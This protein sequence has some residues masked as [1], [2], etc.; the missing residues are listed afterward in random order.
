MAKAP[1]GRAIFRKTMFSLKRVEATLNLTRRNGAVS[2]IHYLRPHYNAECE[3]FLKERLRSSDIEHTRNHIK[4]ILDLANDNIFMSGKRNPK[5][6]LSLN[7]KD[8]RTIMFHWKSLTRQQNKDDARNEGVSTMLH[9]LRTKKEQV[10]V[11]VLSEEEIA[12]GCVTMVD[13]S[14]IV[15]LCMEWYLSKGFPLHRTNK[16]FP[17]KYSLYNE[18]D[19]FKT[20]QEAAEMRL[21]VFFAKEL[22]KDNKSLLYRSIRQSMLHLPLTETQVNCGEILHER[23]R[24]IV[25]MSF[26]RTTENTTFRMADG[27]AFGLGLDISEYAIIPSITDIYFG[28]HSD[29][30]QISYAGLLVFLN[31]QGCRMAKGLFK[32]DRDKNV[33]TVTQLDTDHDDSSDRT[34]ISFL[35]F[36]YINDGQ[37]YSNGGSVNIYGLHEIASNTRK[38]INNFVIK[39]FSNKRK[40]VSVCL[41]NLMKNNMDQDSLKAVSLIRKHFIKHIHLNDAIMTGRRSNLFSVIRDYKIIQDIFDKMPFVG[42]SLAT[43]L[44]RKGCEPTVKKFS[45]ALSNSDGDISDNR[46]DPMSVFDELLLEGKGHLPDILRGI[47]YNLLYMKDILSLNLRYMRNSQQE[48]SY[49]WQMLNPDSHESH[50]RIKMHEA[51]VNWSQSERGHPNIEPVIAKWILNSFS[52]IL[53]NLPWLSKSRKKHLDGVTLKPNLKWLKIQYAEAN[54]AKRQIDKLAGIL[55]RKRYDYSYHIQYALATGLI[56]EEQAVNDF[57]RFCLIFHE[58]NTEWTM[59]MNRIQTYG[60]SQVGDDIDTSIWPALMPPMSFPEGHI[61]CLTS[62]AELEQESRDMSH[63]VR[64]YTETCFTMD[65][66]ILKIV[67]NDGTRGTLQISY[68][69]KRFRIQQNKAQ[70]NNNVSG[71]ALTITKK[72]MNSP[73]LKRIHAS[74]MDVF[75]KTRNRNKDIQNRLNGQQT[76]ENMIEAIGVYWDDY[77]RFLPKKMKCHQIQER[78]LALVKEDN[79]DVNV[80]A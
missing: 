3:A 32:F 73:E 4:A 78:M 15:F 26:T 10:K 46:P 5:A 47:G 1:K 11:N 50:E 52:P 68:N 53:N 2:S 69:E 43:Y 16:T 80:A 64:G 40:N 48:W 55:M 34:F 61:E 18:A 13:V 59:L 33:I 28:N 74:Y 44:S 21:R 79:E 35:P 62:S 36:P 19:R 67:G 57:M 9:E 54:D 42:Y 63:C 37:E 12:L 65:S 51:W 58:R 76:P 14:V 72:F 66:H 38:S 30:Y 23:L 75:G 39:C 56:R 31:P 77:K 24:E 22:Q 60:L 70:S 20:P 7:F 45:S 29:N 71:D 49:N 17:I 8:V 27:V 41:N 6:M 25:D